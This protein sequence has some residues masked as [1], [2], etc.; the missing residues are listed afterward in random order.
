MKEFVLKNSFDPSRC[1]I[2]YR[3]ELN[4][5]QFEVVTTGDGPCLV[6]AGAGSGKTRTITYRVAY[7]IESGVAPENILLVTFTNKAAREML[8]RV[9]GLLG[10]FPKGLWGGTFHSIGNRILRMYAPLV[11]RTSNFNILDEEDARDLIKVCIKELQVDTSARRFPSPT[12]IHSILSYARNASMPLRDVLSRKYAH[13]ADLA[14]I[15]ERI[16]ELYEDRKRQADV[17]DFDDLLLLLHR[18]LRERPDVR[19]RLASQFQYVLVDEYQ[20]TNVI[21]AEIVRQLASAHGNVLVVGDD[22]QSI[23]SFRAAEIRNILNFPEIFP[24]TRTFRLVTNYR[25]TPEILNL[26]NAVIKQNAHQFKKDL[27]AVRDSFELP[28]VVPAGNAAQEA[29]YIAQQILDLRDEGV[30]MRDM[31][32]LFRA[33]YLSQSLEFELMK[34]DVPYEYRGGMKF[35]QRAHIKDVVAHLRILQNHRDEMAW[36]RVLGL[37]PG[38]GLATSGK[39][40]DEIRKHDSIEAAIGAGL[41]LASRAQRG[42]DNAR[43]VLQKAL[44]SGKGPAGMIRVVAGNGYRDYLE[45]EYPDFMDRLEDL[46]QFAVFA[47]GYED[48][49]KFLEDVSLVDDYGAVREA[50]SERDEERIVLSTIHQAKGLEWDAVFVMGLTHGKFPNERALEEDGGLEEE[51]RLFYVATTRARKQLFLTYPIMAGNDAFMLGQPSQFLEEL[52]EGLCEE[53]RLRSAP[54]RRPAFDTSDEPTI[55]LDEF[56]EEKPRKTAPASFLR[57]IDSL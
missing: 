31:A 49:T 9:E 48:L 43:L 12:N 42:W 21:Q 52:P 8:S 27:R 56:G 13:F 46:E 14:T 29:Q 2:D 55:V 33:A 30:A 34:R 25:S 57:D 10:S 44:A 32:V 38:L 17:M 51:R 47:E 23:Y 1:K 50:G 11:N 4:P 6:L 40:V 37:Q 35:F 18:L 19:D 39:I 3:A 41:S 16:G 53:V 28:N 15:I 5:E 54:V 22:A 26:A 45:A 20:D 24:G 7:L 36:V